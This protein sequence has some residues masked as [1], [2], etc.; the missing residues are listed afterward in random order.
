MKSG[1]E[2]LASYF[3]ET[4]MKRADFAHLDQFIPEGME[5]MLRGPDEIRR[6]DDINAVE[7]LAEEA[8]R[9]ALDSANLKPADIDFIIAGNLGGRYPAPMV[10][11]WVHHRLGFPEETPAINVQTCCASFV[12][13]SNV[14]WN[15]VRGGEYKRILVVMSTAWNT[16]GG[17]GNSDPTSP[18][19]KF[20]GDGAG[21]AIVSTRNLKCEFLSY[22]NRTFGEIYHHL[23]GQVR[24]CEHPEILAQSQAHLARGNY[25][26]VDEWFF[27]WF[28]QMG[29]NFA[30]DGITKALG[31]AGLTISDLDGVVIHQAYPFYLDW[32]QGGEEA[33]VSREKWKETSNKYGNIGNVD[34]VPNLEE[35]WKE[36]KIG[37]DSIVALFTP[38]GGGH[39]PCMILKWLV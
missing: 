5:A 37:K 14:A 25:L 17:A 13:A 6:L 1:F 30:M 20:F 39:T 23:N 32:I 26:T 16:G 7:I 18:M 38:G 4:V 28:Q 31:K 22:A 34:V 11:S 2:T 12:D 29:K 21:A 8:A 27:Q 3:P 19:S 36:G 9:R 15:L 24:P 10:G 33:G 35:L